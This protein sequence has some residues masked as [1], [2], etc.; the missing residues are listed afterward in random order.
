MFSEKEQENAIG[1][2]NGRKQEKFVCAL[3]LILFVFCCFFLDFS[4]SFVIR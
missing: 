1:T 2:K 4:L 3:S